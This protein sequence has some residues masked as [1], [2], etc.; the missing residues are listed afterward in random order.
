MLNPRPVPR[1]RATDDPASVWQQLKSWQEPVVWEEA[2]SPAF[3]RFAATWTDE[4]LAE[5]CGD[6]Q[7]DVRHW[8]GGGF[9]HNN[10]LPKD[11]FQK[12]SMRDLQAHLAAPPH[13]VPEYY[14]SIMAHAA[15]SF[16]RPLFDE[17]RELSQ[18][19]PSTSA[20]GHV[21]NHFWVGGVHNVTPLH[22][23]PQ[24]SWHMV[25][26][27]KKRWIMFPPD[28]RHFRA[29]D[30]ISW[31]SGRRKHSRLGCGPLDEER[32]PKLRNTR[33]MLAVLGPGDV[34]YT[35]ACWWHHVTI[36]DETTLS[37]TGWWGHKERRLWPWWRLKIGNLLFEKLSM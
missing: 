24:A 7:I 25:I 28:L 2:D 6:S 33:P 16:A 21:F 27:G 15:A 32:F 30:P 19:L 14:A 12:M 8:R 31:R 10:D 5:M 35:P 22:H 18:G 13:G 9:D 1:R 26:R 20:V 37:V 17:L 3:Q 34:L 4:H 11:L 29:L 23:D 36:C